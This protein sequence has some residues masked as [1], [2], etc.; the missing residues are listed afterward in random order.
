MQQVA[1]FSNLFLMLIAKR[2]MKD[3][4]FHMP[5][6]SLKIFRFT[7]FPLLECYRPYA[8]VRTISCI[9]L[10]YFQRNFSRCRD[11]SSSPKVCLLRVPSCVVHFRLF[12]VLSE[13]IGSPI[14]SS[15]RYSNS[16]IVLF[17]K[18]SCFAQY[19]QKDKCI[20]FREKYNRFGCIKRLSTKSL[21]EL[22]RLQ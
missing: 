9:G 14:S 2:K 4:S 13:C 18:D 15:F 5:W 21:N 11:V 22:T 1:A 16:L 12:R 20:D 3:T 17:K 8:I 7:L 6:R 19:D 10:D